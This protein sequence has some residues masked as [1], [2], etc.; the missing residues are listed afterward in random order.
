MFLY[1]YYTKLLPPGSPVMGLKLCLGMI[2]T[3]LQDV[4]F[5]L[6]G[7]LVGSLKKIFSAPLDGG[8]L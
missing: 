8:E 2:V 7:F 5:G 3:P 6:G 4:I 1:Q